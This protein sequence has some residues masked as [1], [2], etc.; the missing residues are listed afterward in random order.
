[1]VLK[2]EKMMEMEYFLREICSVNP[3]RLKLP[4]VLS[5]LFHLAMPIPEVTTPPHLPPCHQHLPRAAS[6]AGLAPDSGDTQHS[7]SPQDKPHPP[8]PDTGHV[9]VPGSLLLVQSPYDV[10]SHCEDEEA[11]QGVAM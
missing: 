4:L 10:D 9:P 8:E 3:V 2:G 1:M 5:E 6:A 7:P 11:G